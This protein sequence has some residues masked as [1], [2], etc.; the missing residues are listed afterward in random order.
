MALIELA[1]I[2]LLPVVPAY[3]LYAVLPSSADVSGPFKGLNIKLTGAFGGYFLLVLLSSGYVAVDLRG[4]IIVLEDQ[5]TGLEEK[6]ASVERYQVWKI[7]G[8][9]K[10]HGLPESRPKVDQDLFEIALWPVET[11]R[12]QKPNQENMFEYVIEAP[13]PTRGD[14]LAPDFDDIAVYHDEFFAGQSSDLGDQIRSYRNGVAQHAL[15]IDYQS[16]TIRIIEPIVIH[17]DDSASQGDEIA[18]Q[19]VTLEKG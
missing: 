1:A 2:L 15:Q 16:R 3:L 5:I 7:K 8:S 9:I 6:M 10:P 19:E 11:V 12:K 13:I 14:Q 18:N 4:Q 17:Y